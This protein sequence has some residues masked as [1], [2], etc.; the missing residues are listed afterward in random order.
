MHT[1][2]S[3]PRLLNVEYLFEIRYAGFENRLSHLRWC[4]AG[5]CDQHRAARNQN[6]DVVWHL[7]YRLLHFAET[8]LPELHSILHIA[9]LKCRAG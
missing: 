4:K 7:P 8:L 3:K 5:N 9:V 2:L 6:S 1:E